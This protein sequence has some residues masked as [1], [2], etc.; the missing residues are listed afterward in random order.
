MYLSVVV[1]AK[2]KQS[3]NLVPFAALLDNLDS[4]D[5]SDSDSDSISLDP[6][7]NST[8]NKNMRTNENEHLASFQKII[9]EAISRI[10]D[11]Q[12][13]E[14]DKKEAEQVRQKFLKKYSD[15]FTK[16]SEKVML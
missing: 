13:E 11:K 12:K 3:E 15:V 8:D 6:E 16:N 1:P 7:D 5:D 4:D 10:E 9:N 14:E 2:S